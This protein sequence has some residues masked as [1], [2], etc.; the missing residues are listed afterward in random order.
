MV[1]ATGLE[2][3]SGPAAEQAGSVHVA[4]TGQLDG[5]T[6]ALHRL[7]SA[8]ARG[9]D[10]LSVLTATIRV[11]ELAQTASG[12]DVLLPRVQSASPAVTRLAEELDF[13]LATALAATV[14]DLAPMSRR[15][16][17]HKAFRVAPAALALPIAPSAARTLALPARLPTPASDVPG[18]WNSLTA[19]QQDSAVVQWPETLGSTAALP[20]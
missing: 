20:G 13:Q 4:L 10:Q 9:A 17:A 19:A 5:F 18:W 11:E 6:T 7:E 16:E 1:T 8:L 2:G 14:T 12:S 3:W 15:T